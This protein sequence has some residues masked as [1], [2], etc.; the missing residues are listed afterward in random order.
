MIDAKTA[1][2]QHLSFKELLEQYNVMIPRIQRD[3]AQGRETAKEVRNSFLK[4]LESYLEAGSLHR[5]LDFIYG[6]LITRDRVQYFIPLDGQQRLTTLFL[7]HWYL[8]QKSGNNARLQKILSTEDSEYP[9]NKKSKF[10]YEIRSSSS[11][12]CDALVKTDINFDNIEEESLSKIIKNSSWYYLSWQYDPTIQ[13]MLNMLDDIHKIFGKKSYLF[14]QLFDKRIITFQLLNLKDFNLTDDLYIKMNSRG[15]PLSQ[16]ENFKAKF[17]QHLEEMKFDRNRIFYL[18][19]AEVKKEVSFKRYFA[20]NIDTKWANLFW[21]YRDLIKKTD[22]K[23]TA[24]EIEIDPKKLKNSF[25]D[26]LMNFIRVIFTNQYAMSLDANKGDNNY[27]ILLNTEKV[28]KEAKRKKLQLEEI[29]F[30]KYEEFKAL[31]SDAALHL[32]DALDCLE[33]GNKKIYKHLSASYRYYFDEDKVFENALRHDFSSQPERV[34][35]HAYIQFLICSGKNNSSRLEQWMRVMHNFV[36]NTPIDHADQ[37]FRATKSIQKILFELPENRDVIEWLKTNPKIDFFGAQ[38][39]EEKIKAHLITANNKKWEEEIKRAEQNACFSGQIGFI[40]EFAGIVDYYNQHK[41]CIWNEEKDKEFFDKFKNYTDRAVV[42]FREQDKDKYLWER[43][44]LTKGDYLIT[45]RYPRK[46]FLSKLHRDYSWKRLFNISEEDKNN[47][48]K[49]L[50][51]KAVLDDPRF[52]KNNVENSLNIIRQDATNDWRHYFIDNPKLIGYCQQGFISHDEKDN[53]FLFKKSE[54]W[55]T[56]VE[57]YSYN[58]FTK[59]IEPQKALFQPFKKIDYNEAIN[60]NPAFAYL[61]DF[62]LDDIDY[63]VEIS[64]LA[65]SKS[66]EI[67]FKAKG[68]IVKYPDDILKALNFELS[69]YYFSR[70]SDSDSLIATLKALCEKLNLL[71]CSQ[72]CNFAP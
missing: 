10:T 28:Q 6:S 37:I 69:E 20:H 34:L 72:V 18:K 31:S 38:S 15:M 57:M 64:W 40:L 48:D 59:Y 70:F 45:A 47:K 63:E 58:L 30:F 46:S 9:E 44:V 67:A 24:P 27:E 13:S 1:S 51:M 23:K 26:E 39:F 49:R 14:E 29:S 17:E 8:A 41:S 16:F 42:V 66:Y 32:A 7:L 65:E 12:F 71:N 55:H 54:R 3:Y 68:D 5:D 33:N 50:L 60:T 62:S 22:L 61:R 19:F 52:D 21:H 11:E 25:D 35:F 56:N 43:A 2:P 53:I 4:A 36:Y